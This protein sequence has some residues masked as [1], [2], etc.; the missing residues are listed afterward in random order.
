MVN[1]LLLYYSELAVWDDITAVRVRAFHHMHVILLLHQYIGVM[2]CM[3]QVWDS[4]SDSAVSFDPTYSTSIGYIVENDLITAALSN[5]IKKHGN[6]EVQFGK[7]VV[8]LAKCSGDWR[9]LTLEDGT[10]ITTKLLVG[11]VIF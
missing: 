4:C 1:T 7:Q 3:G 10:E 2:Q 6:I 8:G 11:H 5:G 9:T